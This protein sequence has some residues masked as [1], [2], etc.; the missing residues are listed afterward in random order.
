MKDKDTIKAELNHL[1]VEDKEEFE[2]VKEAID[3]I[4]SK[5]E[6]TEESV[7]ETEGIMFTLLT[8]R[9]RHY[10]QLITWLKQ[11]HQL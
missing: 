9:E 5:N 10:Q 4:L 1:S 11:G 7:K 2:Y 8:L 3:R 6:I